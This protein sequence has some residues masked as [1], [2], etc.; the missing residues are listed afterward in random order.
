MKKEY[1]FQ[2]VDANPTLHA[3]LWNQIEKITLDQQNF[4]QPGAPIPTVTAQAVCSVEGITVRFES[5][6]TD[7]VIRYSH[8]NQPAWLDSCVEFF[9]APY[10][11]EKKNYLNFEQSVGGALLIQKGP[12]AADRTYIPHE[13]DEFKTE[14]QIRSNGWCI[15][16]FIPFSFVDKHFLTMNRHFRGNFQFCCEDKGVYL[17]WNRIENPTPAFHKPEYFGNLSLGLNN[18]DMLQ[19][20]CIKYGYHTFRICEMTESG[21]QTRDVLPAANILKVYSV[22]KSTVA[23]LTGMLQ[24]RGLLSVQ[25]KI[26]DYLSEYFPEDVDP[27]WYQ[28]TIADVLHHRTGGSGGGQFNQHTALYNENDQDYLYYIFCDRLPYEIGKEIVYCESNYYIISR[29]IEKITGKK[30]DEWALEN[31][32]NPLHFECAAWARCPQGHTYGGDGL[33]LRTQDLVKLGWV[34]ANHGMFE[35]KQIVSEEWIQQA[36]DVINVD[37]N[38]DYGFAVQ[39]CTYMRPD[40][41][42]LSGAGDQCTVFRIGKPHALAFQSAGAGGHLELLK[43]A[44]ELL[45]DDEKI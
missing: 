18:L 25:D 30:T 6:E 19:A 26:A 11:D 34:Y 15:Q 44:V 7:P 16:F 17:T 3:D 35:G 39:H 2:K 36:T 8:A 21:I 32:F 37:V 20:E 14:R 23:L 41:F 12:D 24:D 22:T 27:K 45:R 10:E 1:I 31:L 4:C 29:I 28:V 40:E 13:D 42:Y 5:N 43:K 38:G 33:C 9:F